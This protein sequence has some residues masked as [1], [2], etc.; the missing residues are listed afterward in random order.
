MFRLLCLVLSLVALYAAAASVSVRD[1]YDGTLD[2]QTQVETFRNIDKLFPSRTVAHGNAYPL[3]AAPRTLDKLSFASLGRA[4]TLDEYLERNRVAAVLVLKDGKIALERYRFGN[5]RQTRW[6]SWSIAKSVTSTL[7][8]AAIKD[9]LVRSLDDPVTRYVPQLAGGAYDGV[10]IR[11]VLQ[12]ASGVRWN[13]A[14]TDPSSDRRKMLDTQIEQRPGAVLDF[15]RTL[16]RAAPPGK[17]WNYSTGETH[18]LGAVVSAAAKRP[19]SQY[20]AEKLWTRFGMESDATWWLDAPNGLEVGG[21]GFSATLRDYGRFALFVL[22]GG[23]AAG[24]QI[25]PPDW[26]PD[27]GQ[28][29][30]VGDGVVNYGY[31]WWGAGNASDP[32]GRRPFMAVGIF[33]Q[34]V[35]IDPA[36]NTAIVLWS[37]RPKP[38]GSPA[39]D[40]HDFFKAA[41]TS[42]ASRP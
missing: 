11:N 19:L 7:L 32:I 34:F 38:T 16:R 6:V 28:P 17:L 23:K 33:G 27:A 21:S 8:G 13:E 24:Q 40:D 30:R 4:V 35:Y 20:L 3:A 22:S 41:T 31:M 10:S 5:T 29:K 1:V 36:H 42:L 25:V 39:I 37:A 12:M 26:F 14:Y 18:V 15:M 2:L 9:G